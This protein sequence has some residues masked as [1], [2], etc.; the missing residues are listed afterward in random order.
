MMTLTCFGKYGPYPK[1]NCAC[2]SY[3]ITYNGKNVII[4]LGCGAL[5]RVFAR[6][7]TS[8]IDALVLSHLHADHM[9]DVLTLRYALDAAKKLGKRDRTLPVYMP[10]EPAAEA[11]LIASNKMIETHYINDGDAYEICGMDVSFALMPHAV[12]SFAM[13]FSAGGRKFVYSG[14]TGYNERIAEFAKDADLLLMEA[15]FLAKNKP[16]NAVHVSAAEAA[17]IGRD[18]NAKRLLLTHIF[19]EY[20]EKDVLDDAV[21]V[22]PGANIIE[23]LKSYEV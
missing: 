3:M 5:T 9:G 11:S 14:D 7:E 8:E 4:D 20:N 10:A 16:D 19:P 22:F 21:R 23:E 1:A 18:A 17:G 2:S 15:A 12:R 6:L 13:S